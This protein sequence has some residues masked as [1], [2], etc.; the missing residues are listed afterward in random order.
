MTNTNLAPATGAGATEKRVS[1]VLSL[2]PRHGF[3]NTPFVQEIIERSIA[4]VQAGFAIHFCGPS[5]SG[6]TTLALHLANQLTRPI[7]LITGDD[8]FG[9]SDLVGGQFGYRKR[10]VVDNFVHSVLKTEED[11]SQRWVDSRLTIACREGFTLVYDEF[12]RSRPEANNAMLSVLEEK[13][14]VLPTM[15]T[16]SSNYLKVHPNFVAIFTSN[17]EDYAGVHKTQDAL[18]D[19]MITI[20]LDYFDRETEVLITSNRSDLELE[21]SSRIVDMVRAFREQEQIASIKPTVRAAIMIARTVGQRQLPVSSQD[22]R[23]LQVCFD[24]L[25]SG[26]V[27]GGTAIP[28]DARIRH[29]QL[30]LDLATQFCAE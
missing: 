26:L 11:M 25:G 12:T 15:R 19:R 7:M 20:Y 21:D 27:R 13:L 24:V 10:K 14:L 6:K 29:R 8:Q 5:G 22:P 4:Y 16:G 1:Q 9:T 17:P 30:I 3:A 2:K 28:V 23:F 18:R